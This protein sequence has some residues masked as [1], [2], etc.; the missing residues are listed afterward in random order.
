MSSHE[1]ITRK[2]AIE[3]GLKRYFI[4]VPCPKG[5]ICERLTSSR[6]CYECALDITG[7]RR[8]DRKDFLS[9]I[10]KTINNPLELIDRDSAIKL[11]LKKYFT[12]VP[13]KHGHLSE[14]RVADW[15]C[16]ECVLDRQR[17]AKRDNPE[18]FLSRYRMS[19]K[20]RDKE[21]RN[22]QIRETYAYE[23]ALRRAEQDQETE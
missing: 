20:K 17:K 15:K 22:E 3:R 2:E 16:N 7:K 14:R 23:R 12:G 21:K 10:E 6:N 5:H 9:T 1:I 19:D 18:I 11:K 13:C 8:K 4:G